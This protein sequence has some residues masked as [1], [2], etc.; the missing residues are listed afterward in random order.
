MALSASK[1][2]RQ[3]VPQAILDKLSSQIANPKSFSILRLHFAV[4]VFNMRH[5]QM[6]KTKKCNWEFEGEIKVEMEMSVGE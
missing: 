5:I 4:F 3:K 2:M 1:S 6:S